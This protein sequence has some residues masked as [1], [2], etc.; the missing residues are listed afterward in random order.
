MAL[1]P[2]T[3]GVY[4]Q[5]IPLLPAS[6]AGVATA[7]PAF[8]GYTQKAQNN[9][10]GIP[11]FTPTRITSML[12]YEEMFGGPQG[13]LYTIDISDQTTP[14]PTER[15]ITVAKGADSNFRLYYNVQMYFANGGGPC[16]I[17]PIGLYSTVTT[18]GAGLVKKDFEDGLAAVSKVDEPT[19]LLYPDV[20][21]L[22]SSDIESIN[23][24]AL[25]QCELLKDRFTI[26]DVLDTG[27][28]SS[29]AAAF[30]G[31]VGSDNLK[32][33]A[34]YYP[35][36][37]TSLNY[38]INQTTLAIASYEEDSAVPTDLG[39][40]I[41][42]MNYAYS[43]LEITKEAINYA[44]I[45]QQTLTEDDADM[46]ETLTIAANDE[47]DN[48]D[49][50]PNVRTAFITPVQAVFGT[51]KTTQSVAAASAAS[52]FTGSGNQTSANAAALISALN[53]LLSAIEGAITA[54]V[55]VLNTESDI[56][57]AGNMDYLQQNNPAVY[58]SIMEQINAE[59]ITLNP[60]GAMAGIYA[61][62]DRERGVWKAP[63]N[64]SVR[65]I[66]G[67]SLKITN[68]EQDGLNV[69]ATSGKSINALRAF[70]GRGTLVWGA[71]TLAG[72]DNEWRYI[73]VRRLFI[74]VEESIQEA[75]QFVVFEPNTANTWLKVKGMIDNFLT[76]LWRDGALAGATTEEAFFVRVGLGTTMTSQDIL[77]GRMIVEVGL[78]AVRPAEFIILQFLHK[79]QE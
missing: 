40:T 10:V 49:T 56:Y 9:G 44:L 34:A 3:P 74:F 73:N 12:E 5:E 21:S 43:A 78:A 32:Y 62:V 70:T 54:M 75:T 30:R 38:G 79:V 72:N 57:V 69:D 61:R 50:A 24:D 20:L 8:I 27:N 14:A 51:I 47:V 35:Y 39:T 2:Q 1:N 28:V 23:D 18:G 16:W 59:R 33:G 64:V 48:A 42:F 11:L 22:T 26:M 4:I 55:N 71:R 58:A 52:D 6:I 66:V 46:C 31:M 67:P 15:T 7:I 76:N 36:L 29:D 41:D 45:A 65:D 53:D 17:V 68:S 77:E 13:H 25:E 63:A 19:L 60:S 37:D